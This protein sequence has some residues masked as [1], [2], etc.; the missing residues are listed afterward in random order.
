MFVSLPRKGE[1][2]GIEVGNIPLFPPRHGEIDIWIVVEGCV[3]RVE[4]VLFLID[5]DR[6]FRTLLG[7]EKHRGEREIPSVVRKN[8]LGE[9]TYDKDFVLSLLT[10][11]EADLLNS[12]KA[13][14][15]T[16][17]VMKDTAKGICQQKHK[18]NESYALL[19]A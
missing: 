14:L 19:H 1:I 5:S 7:C 17:S 9:G 12:L 4:T 16:M 11:H 3:G 13:W 10:G 2:A 18:D 6:I 15:K 8:I